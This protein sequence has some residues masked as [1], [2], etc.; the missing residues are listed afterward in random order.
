MDQGTTF[1][2]QEKNK[3]K[4]TVKEP[5]RKE[6]NKMSL[7][8]FEPPYH[9]WNAKCLPLDQRAIFFYGFENI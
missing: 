4:C 5:K 2:C 7:V 8:G 3:E 9:R 6:K 1:A